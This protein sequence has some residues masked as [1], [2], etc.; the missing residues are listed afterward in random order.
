M[1][2]SDWNIFTQIG[3]HDVLWIPSMVNVLPLSSGDN[4]SG[5][6]V[7]HKVWIEKFDCIPNTIE[8]AGKTPKMVDKWEMRKQHLV[9]LFACMCEHPCVIKFLAIH[10]KTMEAYTLW[11]NGGILQEMLEYNTK[12]SPI[13]EPYCSKGGRYEKA[14]MTCHF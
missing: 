3:R 13:M 12:Y 11:W 10:A 1:E 9:E 8:L 4:S 14:N 2:K 5:Y 6:G 7:V